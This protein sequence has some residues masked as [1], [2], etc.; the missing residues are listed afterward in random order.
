M[1]TLNNDELRDVIKT[2]LGSDTTYLIP[3]GADET[4]WYM[5]NIM[6]LIATHDQQLLEAILEGKE[7]YTVTEW[8]DPVDKD[9]VP[10]EHIKSVFKKEGE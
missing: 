7:T 9:A 1:T 4:E 2:L 8:G 6:G 3:P 10:V 5:D